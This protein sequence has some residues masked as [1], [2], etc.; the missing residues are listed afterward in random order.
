[1]RKRLSAL[2]LAAGLLLIPAAHASA[3]TT[4]QQVTEQETDDDGGGGNWGLLGLL[5]LGGLA[6]LLRRPAADRGNI[7]SRSIRDPEPPRS[8]GH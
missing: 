7:G 1:M 8:S 6:G 5:G 3:Q 2:S 4:T